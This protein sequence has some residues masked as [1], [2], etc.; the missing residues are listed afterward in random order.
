MWHIN[1]NMI[2]NCIFIKIKAIKI[3]FKNES[4]HL[5]KIENKSKDRCRQNLKKKSSVTSP[6][7]FTVELGRV[8]GFP[9]SEPPICC[10]ALHK[11]LVSLWPVCRS[12]AGIIIRRWAFILC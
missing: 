10:L 1:N 9:P 8:A 11:C 7:G 2:T 6:Q 4:K 12:W 3:K 5:N